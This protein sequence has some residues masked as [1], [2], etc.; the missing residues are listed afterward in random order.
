[1]FTVFVIA[2]STVTSINMPINEMKPPRAILSRCLGDKYGIVFLLC[3]LVINRF[4][5]FLVKYSF[6]G[7]VLVACS[8][9]R[10]CFCVFSIDIVLE[11]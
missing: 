7:L 6:V 9:N 3:S 8:K 4:C 10:V 1:M 11:S 2:R 5:G